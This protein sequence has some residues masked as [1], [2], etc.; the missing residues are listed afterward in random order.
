[1]KACES[2]ISPRAM[3]SIFD[4]MHRSIDD[5]AAA[6]SP[7]GPTAIEAEVAPPPPAAPPPSPSSSEAPPPLV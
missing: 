3:A 1:M 2:N 4:A 7:V 5:G 6:A